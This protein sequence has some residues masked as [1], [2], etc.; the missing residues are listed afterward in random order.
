[1]TQKVDSRTEKLLQH[2]YLQI[3]KQRLKKRN[4]E[5][6]QIGA[7]HDKYLLRQFLTI[8]RSKLKEIKVKKWKMDMRRRMS[9]IK[10][11]K[12]NRILKEAWA[13][14]RVFTV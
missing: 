3:W 8:W 11:N 12:D 1:M 6:L 7:R 5:Y 14:S 9:L 2:R 10:T 13:V 4:T